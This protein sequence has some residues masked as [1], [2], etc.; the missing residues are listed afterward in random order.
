MDVDEIDALYDERRAAFLARS[1]I[2]LEHMA[3]LDERNRALAAVRESERRLTDFH[4]R[5]DEAH[6]RVE[7]AQA[8]LRDLDHDSR[9]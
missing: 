6:R 4:R 3:L 9:S 1:E 8:A 2:Q 7:R 5:L